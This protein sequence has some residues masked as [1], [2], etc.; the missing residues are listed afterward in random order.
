MERLTLIDHLVGI[1]EED[2]VIAVW[3]EVDIIVLDPILIQIVQQL[4]SV[5]IMHI[6]IA[7]A[8]HDQESHVLCQCRHIRDRA[9]IVT[10]RVVLRSMH[11]AL[12]V[13]RV[14]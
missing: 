9:V 13:D 12:G 2:A 8:V 11:I 10:T 3:E 6:V 1:V 4:Q 5:L 7:S 14:F